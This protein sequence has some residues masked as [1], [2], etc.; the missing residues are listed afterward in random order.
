MRHTLLWGIGLILAAGLPLAAQTLGE[1][2]GE[3]QDP[4]GAVVAGAS[5]KAT[6]SSTGAARVTRSN[7][8]GI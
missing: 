7:G 4:S 1:I 8:A 3:V 6:N 2:T 5:V